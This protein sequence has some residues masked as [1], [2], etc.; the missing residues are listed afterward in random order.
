MSCLV[1]NPEQNHEHDEQN[2]HR[3]ITKMNEII[4][5]KEQKGS[6]VHMFLVDHSDILYLF[7][8]NGSIIR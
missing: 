6:N 4:H 8:L 7:Y 5:D 1:Q 3:I 2:I